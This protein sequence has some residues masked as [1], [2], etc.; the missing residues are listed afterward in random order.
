MKITVISVG[1]IRE[2]YLNEGIKE[3]RKRLGKFCGLNLL[4]VPDERIPEVTNP[5]I[6]DK[7]LTTEG[8]HMEKVLK[9]IPNS[10]QYVIALDVK[11]EGY[12]SEELASKI[13]H[14]MVGGISHIVFLIGGS[15]GMDKRILNRA[16]ARLSLSPMTFTHQMTRL[17]LLE[18][19]YRVFKIQNNEVYHK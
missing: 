4:E 7:I 9:G 17:I 5:S 2:K 6:I 3:Y 14:L 19:I 16:N 8:N 11:G 12:T 15:L 10:G 13:S 1:K 18:Q